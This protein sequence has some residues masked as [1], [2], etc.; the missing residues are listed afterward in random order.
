MDWLELSDLI[1]DVG[2]GTR[3]PVSKAAVLERLA[4][5]EPRL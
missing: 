1:L 5:R 2:L 3:R 4:R